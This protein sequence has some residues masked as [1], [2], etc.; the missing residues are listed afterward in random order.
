MMKKKAVVIDKAGV[1]KGTDIFGV[2]QT[3]SVKIAVGNRYTGVGQ[4]RF[5]PEWFGTER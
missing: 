1:K 3:S 5:P 4:N 2:R